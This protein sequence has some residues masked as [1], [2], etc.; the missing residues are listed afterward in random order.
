M[1]VRLCTS[2]IL[3]ELQN[4]KNGIY[5]VKDFHPN[6]LVC[7]NIN[8]EMMCFKFVFFFILV[9]IFLTEFPQWEKSVKKN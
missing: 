2:E 6:G 4:S 3:K 5:L 7:D 9:N 1:E 8:F